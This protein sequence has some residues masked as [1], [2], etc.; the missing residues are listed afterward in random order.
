MISE[1]VLGI[2][3]GLFIGMLIGVIFVLK[4]A[5]TINKFLEEMLDAKRKHGTGEAK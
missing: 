4:L 2:C 3:I 5:R 1:L